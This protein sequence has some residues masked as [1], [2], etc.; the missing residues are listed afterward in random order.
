M[1]VDMRQTS[2]DRKYAGSRRLLSS[3]ANVEGQMLLSCRRPSGLL[4]GLNLRILLQVERE[5]FAI[6]V[7]AEKSRTAED[8]VTV[9]ERCDGRLAQWVLCE[10]AGLSARVVDGV[11]VCAR[12]L[13]PGAGIGAPMKLRIGASGKC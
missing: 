10:I 2:D 6:A 11:R 12:R 8:F 1:P 13:S 9:L 7:A 3:I 4:C 5:R